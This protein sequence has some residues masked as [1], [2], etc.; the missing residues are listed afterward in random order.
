[1][2]E[3]ELQ[4]LNRADLLEMM[5]SLAEESEVLRKNIDLLNNKIN[6]RT[7]M[8]NEAGSI[9]EAAL[10]INGVFDAAQDAANQYLENVKLMNEGAQK[11]ADDLI[12]DAQIRC[13]EMEADARKNVEQNMDI[14]YEWLSKSYDEVHQ[15]L[16]HQLNNLRLS[17][18]QLKSG[19]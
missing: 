8:I 6:T 5:T 3:R 16:K 7:I 19:N 2:T 10:K 18:I 13:A 9:A 17:Q 1:M 14:I 4:K 15:G 12:A 11:R